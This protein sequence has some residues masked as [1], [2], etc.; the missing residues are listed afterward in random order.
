VVAAQLD[1]AV[2]RSV[3]A[4]RLERTT[5]KIAYWQRRAEEA[6]RAHCKRRRK[7]LRRVRIDLRR[8]IRCP[9]WA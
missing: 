7:E 6:A 5:T 1:T 2:P 4:R 3:L 9:K 8:A